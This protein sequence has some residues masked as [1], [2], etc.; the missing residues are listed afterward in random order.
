MDDRLYTSRG[1]RRARRSRIHQCERHVGISSRCRVE[2]RR[3][4]GTARNLPRTA[5][6]FPQIAPRR[7]SPHPRKASPPSQ[8]ARASVVFAF[9]GGGRV[10]PGRCA[11][12]VMSSWGKYRGDRMFAVRKSYTQTVT[13]EI[14]RSW[15]SKRRSDFPG[16]LHG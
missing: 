9:H 7:L 14:E 1:A 4:R 13:L 10:S 16:E 15:F 12:V 6:T 8:L 5:S 3:R 11:V 2:L